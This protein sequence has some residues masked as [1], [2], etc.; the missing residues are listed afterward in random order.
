MAEH[1][2][3]GLD[4]D[5]QGKQF[6][7]EVDRGIRCPQCYGTGFIVHTTNRMLPPNLCRACGHR[8]RAWFQPALQRP[9]VAA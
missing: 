2:P 6:R 1:Y 4:A 5:E 7:D 9:K 3:G 8:W